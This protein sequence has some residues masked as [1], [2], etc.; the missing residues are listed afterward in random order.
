MKQIVI[1]S[2][3]RKM[4]KDYLKILRTKQV[5]RYQTPEERLEDFE[6][7]LRNNQ[8]L[9]DYAKYV[10]QIRR[11]YSII[12]ILPPDCF[13][14]FHNRYFK[15]LT[16]NVDLS[17][18]IT[19]GRTTME[20]YEWISDRMRYSDVRSTWLLPFIRQQK[21]KACCYCNAQYAATYIEEDEKMASYD[22]DHYYPQSKYPYLSTSFFNLV[23]SCGCCNR[24][25][26]NHDDFHYPLYVSNRKQLLQ[27]KLRPDSIIRYWLTADA[28][29][30]KIELHDGIDAPLGFARD[31]DD[32]FH[33]C[34]IYT[35][36]TDEAEEIIW[37]SRI[38]NSSYRDQ[39]QQSFS[40]LF[41][42]D[43][44]KFLLLYFGFYYKESDILKRPLSKLKQD[45]AKQLGLFGFDCLLSRKK[46]EEKRL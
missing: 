11:L 35:A 27:L 17:K 16:Q 42:N 30:L 14:W 32:V 46:N 26:S 22:L 43:F 12:V 10:S 33:I 40:R 24:H 31:Y 38:Y 19:K 7:E 3:I 28:D 9:P 37:K 2:H 13:D 5:G 6:N 20:F 15:V 29:S 21:I 45:I 25:K 8:N 44:E 23:P 39:L 41:G 4:A 18:S 36:H 34:E 1:E